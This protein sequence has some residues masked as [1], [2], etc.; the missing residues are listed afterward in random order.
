MG[1]VD[2]VALLAIYEEADL[3]FRQGR[4]SD[5]D[6]KLREIDPETAPLLILAAWL[7]ATC[8]ARKHLPYWETLADASK[9]RVPWVGDYR[10]V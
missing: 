2:D 10:S 1:D 3:A 6:A 4:F 7:S 8:V 9:T 5:V